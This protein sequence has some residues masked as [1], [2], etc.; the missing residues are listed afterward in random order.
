MAQHA[1][2]AELPQAAAWTIR[3]ARRSDAATLAAVGAAT[4]RETY[5]ADTRPADME[6]FL[7]AAYRDEDVRGQLDDP[8]SAFFLAEVADATAGFAQLRNDVTHPA[9]TGSNPTYLA[10]LYLDRQFQGIGLGAGMMQQCLDEA[11]KGG[12]DVLWLGV[13]ER[14][15]RAI[16]FYTKWDFVAVGEMPFQF[17]SERQHDIVMQRAVD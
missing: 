1:L 11:R 13:W 16:A 17:G 7:V 5:A 3:R 6:A 12:H 2:M 14:N 10:N 4:F 9:V 8:R 15:G